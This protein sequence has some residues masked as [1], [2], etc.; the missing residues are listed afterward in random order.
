M[1]RRGS[2]DILTDMAV[3][4][5]H[6][7]LHRRTSRC[8]DPT[9]AAAAERF[10]GADSSPIDRQEKGMESGDLERNAVGRQRQRVAHMNHNRH[11]CLAVEA[12]LVFV[13][14]SL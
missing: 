3:E 11:R 2:V 12:T 1:D 14:R 8:N 5:I 13:V 10:V 6:T 4:D 7:Q 9:F